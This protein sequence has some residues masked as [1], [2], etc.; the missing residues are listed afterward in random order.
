MVIGT[1]GGRTIINT[2]LQVI[3]NVIDHKM[4]IAQAIE[5]PRIHHQWLP[6]VLDFE[7]YGL[8]PDTQLKLI[9]K[10]HSINEL[11]HAAQGHAMGITK[12]NETGRLSGAAD[13]R[14]ADGG[15]AG[16]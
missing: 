1:P 15:V 8:S 13:S 9:E 10:C 4:N 5:A 14:S 7:L 16:Y 3:V 6:D 11:R 12:N 2:V